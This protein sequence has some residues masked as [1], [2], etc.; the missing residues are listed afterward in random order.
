MDQAA[1]R[2]IK[3]YAKC[4]FLITIFW[5][6][7]RVVSK[8]MAMAEEEPAADNREETVDSEKVQPGEHKD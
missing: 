2:M 5:I 7:P 1:G 8:S 6:R 3:Y 4:F